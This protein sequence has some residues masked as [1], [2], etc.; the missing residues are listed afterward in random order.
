MADGTLKVGTITTSSGSG[1]I[2]LGQSG[3]TVS[4]PSGVTFTNSGTA[5]GFGGTNT[6]YFSAYLSSTQSGLNDDAITKINLNAEY[7]DSNNAFDSTT[8]YR[9][10][11]P[12]GEG[13][14]YFL[15]AKF[16]GSTQADQDNKDTQVYIYKNGSS[17]ARG[18]GLL[19]DSS[20]DVTQIEANASII[21]TLAAGDY[22]ELYGRV[23]SSSNAGNNQAIA[24]GFTVLSGYKLVE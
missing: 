3:E 21:T 22:I 13:G 8:N 12:S 11:V 1:T 6:P 10:T 19:T 15:T 5:T 24:N 16:N 9:F 18:R 23:N 17:L 4:V 14:E 20:S 7:A 2:T